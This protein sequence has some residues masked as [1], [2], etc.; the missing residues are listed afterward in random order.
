MTLPKRALPLLLAML[1]LLLGIAAASAGAQQVWFA[2]GDAFAEDDGEINYIEQLVPADLVAQ[3]LTYIRVTNGPCDADPNT[4]DVYEANL[5]IPQSGDDAWYGSLTSTGTQAAPL[6]HPGD[7]NVYLVPDG[8][9]SR[10]TVFIDGVRPSVTFTVC[11]RK[12]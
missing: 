5:S 7:P 12:P 3:G 2:A 9:Q 1:V 6:H 11:F 8:I 10:V 4:F